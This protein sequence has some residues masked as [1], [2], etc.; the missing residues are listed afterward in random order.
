VYSKDAAYKKKEINMIKVSFFVIGFLLF[1]T[2]T[3]SVFS[4]KFCEY[5]HKGK[6][7]LDAFYMSQNA[8]RC[9]PNEDNSYSFPVCNG[10]DH[11]LLEKLRRVNEGKMYPDIVYG[12]YSIAIDY[13]L[14]S[15]PGFVYTRY[16]HLEESDKDSIKAS[17]HP[18]GIIESEDIILFRSH[19]SFAPWLLNTTCFDELSNEINNAKFS[20]L[21]QYHM[22]NGLLRSLYNNRTFFKLIAD[23][24]FKEKGAKILGVCVKIY[25]TDDFCSGCRQNILALIP[26]L[27]KRFASILKCSAESLPVT[28]LGFAISH[29]GTDYYNT[30]NQNLG[31]DYPFDETRFPTFEG[32]MQGGIKQT[33]LPVYLDRQPGTPKITGEPLTLIN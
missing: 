11:S 24:V 29:Y 7:D 16:S 26:C 32:I 18:E 8:K 5:A 20:N 3:A 1:I 25:C 12:T 22:E 6:E 23:D 27:Q 19:K 33:I 28:I 2:F 15:K 31:T 9:F 30:E 21:N 4:C 10:D 17:I 14:E 13:S